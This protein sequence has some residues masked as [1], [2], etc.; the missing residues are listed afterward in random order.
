M[1]PKANGKLKVGIAMTGFIALLMIAS[2]FYTPYDPYAM[3]M[4]L[5]DKLQLPSS[6][7]WLGTDNFGRDILS[8]LMAG[9]KH[10]MLTAAST[11]AISLA[12]GVFLG[13][14]AGYIGK[15]VDEAIMRLMDAISA[16]PGILLALVLVAV[17]KQGPQA[18]ILALSILF[19]PSFTRISRGG[20]LQ[21]KSADFVKSAEVFGA[22]RLRIIFFHM[23]PNI[24]PTLLSS[25]VLGLSSAIMSESS[26]SYLGLGL[27]PP[28]PSWGRMLG[29]AQA[30]LLIAPWY[31]AVTGLAI[32]FCVMGLNLLGEGIREMLP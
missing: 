30:V 29:E 4:D 19:V 16:F 26:M 2:F 9:I 12:I 5:A 24:Y 8:R 20:L 32:V 6:A 22:S 13:F 14:V 28:I 18:I 17:L 1:R 7:H 31:A 3:S 23:L 27:Q 25:I 11:V 15:A 10:T 21:L